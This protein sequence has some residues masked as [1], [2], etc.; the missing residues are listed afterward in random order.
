MD[1]Y[2]YFIP[3]DAISIE[4]N[5]DGEPN[6]IKVALTQNATIQAYVRDVIPY[7][8]GNIQ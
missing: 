4:L 7:A 1:K 6:F 5:V 2:N 3:Q 8:D